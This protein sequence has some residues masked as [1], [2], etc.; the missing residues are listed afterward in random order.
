MIFFGGLKAKS[1][2]VCLDGA[3]VSGIGITV[4]YPNTILLFRN[5]ENN[6]YYVILW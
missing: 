4:V 3:T 2:G 1:F 5:S 6:Y